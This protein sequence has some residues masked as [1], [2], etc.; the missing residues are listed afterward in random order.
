MNPDEH[1]PVYA[2]L[3]NPS[4][5]DYAGRLAAVFFM[6]G[7]NFKCGFCHNAA[8]M[9]KPRPGMSWRKLCKGCQRFVGDWVDG[10]VITGGEPTLSP[11]LPELIHFF[12]QYGWS[13]KLDTNGSNPGL[14]AECLPLV[15]YVAMDIKAG[16]SGYPALTGFDDVDLLGESI[17]LIKQT[18]PDY[19]FRT[20]IIE[21]FHDDD[22]MIEIAGI[23]AGARRYIVQPFVPSEELP[24]TAYREGTR[25]SAGRLEA[26][27]SL[28][29]GCAEEVSVRGG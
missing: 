2:Y 3:Q 16:F 5:V 14:L 11:E 27:A 12:K 10:A 19:E 23:V 24:V 21:S 25:T 9:G 1:S 29:S 8:L 26:V 18:A 20:T 17:E 7:C 6:T 4:M 13:V 15:D 28:V 22:Q